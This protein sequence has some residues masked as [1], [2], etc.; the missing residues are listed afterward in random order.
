MEAAKERVR[1]GQLKADEIPGRFLTTWKEIINVAFDSA[2]PECISDTVKKSFD[3][4]ILTIRESARTN[5]L[6]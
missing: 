1:N 2:V 6:S 3:P 5:T 4:V